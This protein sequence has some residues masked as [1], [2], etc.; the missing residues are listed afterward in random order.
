MT[1]LY[2]Q[3]I[4][5]FVNTILMMSLLQTANMVLG[6]M[7]VWSTVVIVWAVSH[8]IILPAFV[9]AVYVSLDTSRLHVLTVCLMT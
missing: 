8:A 2:G 3:V 6:A 5:S 4:K 7:I 9:T 1:L